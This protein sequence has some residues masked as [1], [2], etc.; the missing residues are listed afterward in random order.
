MLILFF[1]FWLILNGH[2]ALDI[3]M[4]EIVI[5][6]AAISGVVFYFLTHFTKWTWKFEKFFIANLYLFIA[7]GFVLLWN[8]I[9]SNFHVIVLILKR[10]ESPKPIIISFNVPLEDEMLRSILANSITITP[11]TISISETSGHFTVHALKKEF[12]E[13]FENSTL[14]KL[15][16]KM[17]AKRK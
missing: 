1:L 8:I 17:E 5:F 7:Y 15:L 9:T 6:G 10:H 13:G 11:G 3:A 16:L 12:I 2:F 4:L 14:V